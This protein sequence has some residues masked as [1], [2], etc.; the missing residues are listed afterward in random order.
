[1]EHK[2]SIASVLIACLASLLLCGL[3]AGCEKTQDDSQSF[4]TD[5]GRT[6]SLPMT[7]RNIRSQY[8]NAKEDFP[9]AWYVQDTIGGQLSTLGFLMQGS[10]IRELNISSSGL[11]SEE[12]VP[13]VFENYVKKIISQLDVQPC[14]FEPQEQLKVLARYANPMISIQFATYSY[15]GKWYVDCHVR[16]TTPAR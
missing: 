11:S 14:A 5:T 16:L 13:A 8:P 15:E 3:P 4:Q 12:E 7:V 1:M 9:I 10:C 6:I 2:R